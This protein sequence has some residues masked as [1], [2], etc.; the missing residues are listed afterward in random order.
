[1]ELLHAEFDN[2]D[3]GSQTD[4]W[5]LKVASTRGAHPRGVALVIIIIKQFSDFEYGVFYEGHES[6][7]SKC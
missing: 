6:G 1:M 2:Q 5:R 7:R 3:V 4:C